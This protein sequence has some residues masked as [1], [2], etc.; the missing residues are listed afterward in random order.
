MKRLLLFGALL[1]IAMAADTIVKHPRD[2]RFAPRQYTPPA[3]AD[4]R[5]KLSN[6]ATA[7]LVEDHEFPLVTL[8]V[9]IRTGDYLEPKEKTGLAQLMGAQVRA[10]GTKSKPPAVFDEET[11]FLAAQI[12]SAVGDVSGQASLN[13]LTKDVDAGLALFVDM[14]RNPGFAEDRLK[15]AK[16]QLLQSME[17][18]NDSTMSI[19]RREFQRLCEARSTSP[20]RRRRRLRSKR[21][22]A[23]T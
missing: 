3:A 10:G 16:S 7:F 20:R 21:S 15:L 4:F 13:C 9:L 19:E 1:G 11:A 5:H 23:R 8:S 12:S 22:P 17:R 18:R 6:G 2:L 14:L